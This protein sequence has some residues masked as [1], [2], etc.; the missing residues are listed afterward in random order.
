MT[1]KYT[2]SFVIAIV[3][4]IG[5]SRGQEAPI[6]TSVTS[7][8]SDGYF[9]TS[10]TLTCS[11]IGDPAPLYSWYFN[12][13]GVSVNQTSGEYSVSTA[14]DVNA[15]SYVC[16]ASNDYGIAMSETIDMV[17]AYIGD[18]SDVD[19]QTKS[20]TAGAK[21]SFLCRGQPSSAPTASYRWTQYEK[22]VSE[23]NTG[24][25]VTTD[26]RRQIDQATGTMYFA[27]TVTSDRLANK[28]FYGCVAAIQRTAKVGS[29]WDLTVNEPSENPSPATTAFR[30]PSTDFLIVVEGQ[31]QS[32]KCFF[33]G[34]PTPS[35][36]WTRNSVQVS[37]GLSEF[38]TTY[39]IDVIQLSDDGAIITCIGS[40][41]LSPSASYSYTLSVQVSPT[42]D[43]SNNGPSDTFATVGDTV[44]FPCNPR[45]D[46]AATITWY[47]NGN[48]LDAI[49]LPPRY[50]LYADNT[51][52]T[53]T[54]VE[55][56]DV[57]V[58]TCT[59]SNAHGSALQQGRLT[60][61]VPTTVASSPSNHSA[62]SGQATTFSC[63]GDADALTN[64]SFYWLHNN[65]RVNYT[66]ND[67]YVEIVDNECILHLD[68]VREE[69]T[70]Y[71]TC[72]ATNSYSEAYSSEAYLD[73][74]PPVVVFSAASIW[75]VWLI[76]GIL[77]LLL[78]LFVVL[79]FYCKDNDGDTYP[80]DEIEKDNG[81]NPE[82]ELQDTGMKAFEPPRVS[83]EP[84]VWTVENTPNASNYKT[85]TMGS[86]ASYRA[87]PV[88]MSTGA[89]PVYV[90]QQP[91]TFGYG[92]QQQQQQPMSPVRSRPVT[93][94]SAHVDYGG[95]PTWPTTTAVDERDVVLRPSPLV[96]LPP[97]PPVRTSRQQLY[98]PT[99]SPPTA[100]DQYYYYDDN[101]PA[102][103]QADVDAVLVDSGHQ[104]YY[105]QY[106]DDGY[107]GGGGAGGHGRAPSE[108]SV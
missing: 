4:L 97:P 60:V 39:T 85:M 105:Q 93:P 63:V 78:I 51:N 99:T 68:N 55:Q 73:V 44:S 88:N 30:N 24:T 66:D 15:G 48:E 10:I 57:M 84:Q 13:N 80:V 5:I 65:N 76:L 94:R 31:S 87:D 71:Y 25:D 77:L 98:S 37:S 32:F 108:S 72:V 91:T 23:A 101:N 18:F 46:P 103:R 59:A 45:A 47:T 26:A 70:G 49:N 62:H 90:A 75:Y 102:M 41:T 107:G 35:I 27:N 81:N 19:S 17:K 100:A 34:N 58:V 89:P 33:Y 50:Q 83:G 61:L 64:L 86:Q 29:F 92:Q 28:P 106:V 14:T 22:A 42:F 6:V 53:I 3:S 8:P 54:N 38:N 96:L 79:F 95:Q 12:G 40:N 20:V 11:A 82:K 36:Q 16:R 69:H 104:S 2:L 52:L 1:V 9:Y 74:L 67:V 56:T 21:S 43:S 7:N